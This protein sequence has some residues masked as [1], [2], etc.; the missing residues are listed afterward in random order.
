MSCELP[1]DDPRALARAVE[2]AANGVVVHL[3]RGGRAVADVVPHNPDDEFAGMLA[4][5][6]ARLARQRAEHPEP[7][8]RRKHWRDS[9]D[10]PVDQERYA[11]LLAASG[12]PESELPAE[13]ARL[14]SERSR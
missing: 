6:D 5:L 7:D 14:A 10:G 2:L 8:I 3:V 12:V 9:F 13:A 11:A 4:D 1:A